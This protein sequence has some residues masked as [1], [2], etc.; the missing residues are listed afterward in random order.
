MANLD[1]RNDHSCPQLFIQDKKCFVDLSQKITAATV[2]TTTSTV[3]NDPHLKV[4]TG[5]N[6]KI[7]LKKI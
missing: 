1:S 5:E 6:S 3:N 4:D 7:I 2:K